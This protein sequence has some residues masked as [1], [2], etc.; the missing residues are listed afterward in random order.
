[1]LR[2]NGF[3]HPADFSIWTNI[4]SVKGSFRN[5][6][7]EKTLDGDKVV[8]DGAT[9]L[10]WQQGGSSG[11]MNLDHVAGYVAGLNKDRFAGFS[12]WRLPT[13]DEL[14]SLI[15]ARKTVTLLYISPVFAERQKRCWSADEVKS[16]I[17]GWGRWGVIFI[18]GGIFK[19]GSSRLLHVRAVR[20]LK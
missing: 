2:V 20:S 16:P 4:K 14:A 5:D 12:N 19:Y 1:M 17:G 18:D 7:S 15:E 8:I 10:M 13:I 6:F 9:G 11:P 3:N